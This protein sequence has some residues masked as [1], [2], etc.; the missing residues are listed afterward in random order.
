MDKSVL[1][2]TDLQ[3]FCLQIIIGIF[4]KFII[5]E[6]AVALNRISFIWLDSKVICCV[7]SGFSLLFSPGSYIEQIY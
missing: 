2:R 1:I 6:S 4:G 3:I 7:V 5:M